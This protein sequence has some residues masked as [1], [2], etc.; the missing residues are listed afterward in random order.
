MVTV[1]A[2]APGS[3]A[4]ELK[5][6]ERTELKNVV[7]VPLKSPATVTMPHL[8]GCAGLAQSLMASCRPKV[9]GPCA[10]EKLA[11]MAQ[12]GS[13]PGIAKLPHPETE[14]G[15]TVSWLAPMSMVMG[16]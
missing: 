2:I 8:V 7:S 13:C 4:P 14:V 3:I 1:A 10:K 11:V 6:G 5:V 9:P 15:V 16:A 12:V